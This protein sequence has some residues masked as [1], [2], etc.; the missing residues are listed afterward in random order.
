VSRID[1]RRSIIAASDID[2]G[3]RDVIA[4]S[5]SLCCLRRN[6]SRRMSRK[7][8]RWPNVILVR[9]ETSE[10]IHGMHAQKASDTPRA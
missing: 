8:S 7:F 3:K 10:D 4:R 2:P 9:I 1:L 5:G 6:H